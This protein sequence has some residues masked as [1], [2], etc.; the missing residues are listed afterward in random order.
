LP[1]DAAIAP[2]LP[3]VPGPTISLGMAAKENE[4]IIIAPRIKAHLQS[5]E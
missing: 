4:E 1:N 5:V 3:M 2:S